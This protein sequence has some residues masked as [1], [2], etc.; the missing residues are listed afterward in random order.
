MERLQKDFREE[1][2]N[3]WKKLRKIRK[4]ADYDEGDEFESPGV[5]QIASLERG[6]SEMYKFTE[7]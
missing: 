5:S 7:G 6:M 3:E 1:V 4:V 2:I